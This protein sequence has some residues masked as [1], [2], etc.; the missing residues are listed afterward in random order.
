LGRI[1][2]AT[3]ANGDIHGRRGS[4]RRQQLE[5]RQLAQPTL[6]PVSIDGR[7]LVTGNHDGDA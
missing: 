2:F 6:E 1:C 4:H 5:T 7:V 3:G